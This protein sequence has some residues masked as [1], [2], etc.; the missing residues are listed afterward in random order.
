MVSFRLLWR[1]GRRLV[2]LVSAPFLSGLLY[3]LAAPV[4]FPCFLS[5][6]LAFVSALLD[7]FG[8]ASSSDENSEDFPDGWCFQ[9]NLHCVVV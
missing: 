9:P 8:E 1:W 5:T 6:V 2:R 3:A 7:G 4:E